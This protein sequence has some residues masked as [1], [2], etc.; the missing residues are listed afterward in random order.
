ML[1][2]QQK[3]SMMV[4]LTKAQ[5]WNR[6][7]K[8]MQKAMRETIKLVWIPRSKGIDTPYKCR[9]CTASANKC[10][11]H[12]CS[13]CMIGMFTSQNGC[14]NTPYLDWFRASDEKIGRY[15]AKRMLRF[16]KGFL[17]KEEQ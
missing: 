4:R 6:S 5:C 3:G 16:L 12:K 9:L 7:P 1:Y 2:I 8:Y 15:H 10:D 14:I 11:Y 13:K 17:P